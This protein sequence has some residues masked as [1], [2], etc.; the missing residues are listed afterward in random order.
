M[1]KLP[2]CYIFDIDGTVADRGT[3]SPY[4]YTKVMDDTVKE[5]IQT[6][7]KSLRKGSSNTRFIFITGRP[8]SCRTDTEKWLYYYGFEN[9][10]LI[11]RP[12]DN[13][14]NNAI[15]KMNVFK[16]FIKE[17]YKVIAVFED[18]DRAVEMYRKICKITAIQV[19]EG[20]Y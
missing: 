11:M 7:Y 5:D 6:I 15:F 10:G 19:D 9:D 14:E 20:K 16:K 4:D 17:V 13:R 2:E 18:S 8:E 1:E 3:R 12:D